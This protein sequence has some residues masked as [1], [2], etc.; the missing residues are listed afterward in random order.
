MLGERGIRANSVAPGPVWTPLIPLTMP[1][2]AVAGFGDQVPLGRPA[3]PAELAPIYVMR[4]YDGSSFDMEDRLL[5]HL[6]IVVSMKLR[7]DE[8]FFLSWAVTH[9]EGGGRNAIWVGNGIPIRIRFSGSV[10]PTI[11]RE[12]A[13]SMALAANSN[14][15]IFITDEFDR[16]DDGDARSVSQ[17]VG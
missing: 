10:Q 6:Q 15:G 11:N 7:R 5:A 12:W 16:P 17:T 13:E 3:Q 4:H 2:E 9:R 14:L 8:S 1:P